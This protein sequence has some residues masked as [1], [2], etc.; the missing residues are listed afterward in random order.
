MKSHEIVIRILAEQVSTSPQ[1][2]FEE[3]GQRTKSQELRLMLQKLYQD[4]G[5]RGEFEDFYNVQMDKFISIVEK[6]IK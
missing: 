2:D 3:V 4:R 5:T 1:P 6:G